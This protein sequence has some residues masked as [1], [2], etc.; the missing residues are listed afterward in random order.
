VRQCSFQFAPR[1]GFVRRRPSNPK[2]R[3]GLGFIWTSTVR[4]ACRGSVSGRVRSGATW[5]SG[6]FV[7]R[8]HVSSRCSDTAESL[9]FVRTS[10]GQLHASGSFGR[11]QPTPPQLRRRLGSFVRAGH[12]VLQSRWTWH[13]RGHSNCA[14]AWV[15]SGTRVTGIAARAGWFRPRRSRVRLGVKS[16]GHERG[17][18]RNPRE[19]ITPHLR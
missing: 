18:D 9:G 4:A 8:L 19:R 12:K 13:A 1:P 3:L 7:R 15:R 14:A 5:R 16:Q 6:S 2:Q 10:H 17:S 11:G